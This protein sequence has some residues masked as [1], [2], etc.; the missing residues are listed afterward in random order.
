MGRLPDFLIIGAMKA[1]TTSLYRDLLA[2]P[3]VFFPAD[4]EP[5]NLTDD[6][7]LTKSGRREYELLFSRASE[8]QICG[9]AS[10]TYTKEPELS[11]AAKRAREVLGTNVKIVY[12][13]REPVERI[14]SQHFHEYREG[15]ASDNIDEEVRRHG[16]Y[17]ATSSY[18]MQ[19]TPWI[20]EFGADQVKIIL[21]ETYVRDRVATIEEVSRFI[22]APPRIESVDFDA[23]YNRGEEA[24]VA[25][26]FWRA[27]AES[28]FYRRLVRPRLPMDTRT[29]LRNLVSRKRPSRPAPPARATIEYLREQL[30]DD[31]ARLAS[32]MGRSE[33]PWGDRND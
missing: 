5:G 2:N 3:T 26:G 24:G 8:S 23:R 1:G 10:T 4:K 14:I 9:D 27:F 16:R 6:R 17:V 33:P 32:L 25:S 20:E 22:G 31:T 18:A 12:L 13:V 19:V 11:G 29:S 30:R 28:A 7:V 21:F 15:L